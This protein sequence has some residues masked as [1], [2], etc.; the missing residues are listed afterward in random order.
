M[1]LKNWSMRLLPTV[2]LLVVSPLEPP[3]VFA[4]AFKTHKQHAQPAVKGHQAFLGVVYSL[5]YNDFSLS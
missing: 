4:V 5:C 2:Q 1:Q 3:Y